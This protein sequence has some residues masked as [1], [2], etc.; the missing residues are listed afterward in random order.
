[1]HEVFA[2]LP[3]ETVE[4][5]DIGVIELC[6]SHCFRTK[7]FDHL[8]L[9]RE[10]RPQHFDCHLSLQHKVDALKDGA[11]SAFSYFLSDLV[12]AYY[13]ADHLLTSTSR[14]SR[15]SLFPSSP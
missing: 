3:E 10:F 1:N 2:A 8:R 13:A 9:A 7:A 11:H 12:I 15:N 5:C 6:E 14:V 4:R